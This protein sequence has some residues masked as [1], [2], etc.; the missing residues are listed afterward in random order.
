M[1]LA[2]DALIAEG[3][4]RPAE[5]IT[6]AALSCVTRWGMA[7]T[8]LDDIAREAGCSRAT[9]YRLHPGGKQAV[10]DAMRAH[11]LARLLADLA[12]ELD[13][14][15]TLTDLLVAAIANAVQAVRDNQA[16]Q[17]LMAHEPGEVLAHL[18]FDALDPL[19]AEATEFGAPYLER[20]LDPT[21][22]RRTAEWVTRLILAYSLEPPHDL[23]DPTMAAR[24]VSAFVLPGLNA[25]A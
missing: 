11:E 24:F 17:Y 14:T 12:V 1:A 3:R 18:S 5:R 15:D 21:T 19:L 10:F 20:Y 25:A 13:R 23:A 2:G 4:S 6:A 9:I 8:T 7:K 16:L 22:A